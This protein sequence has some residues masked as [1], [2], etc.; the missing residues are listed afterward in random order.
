MLYLQVL[1]DRNAPGVYSADREF[2]K[3]WKFPSDMQDDG[4]RLMSEMWSSKTLDL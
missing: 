1:Q 3:Q 2:R 4:L